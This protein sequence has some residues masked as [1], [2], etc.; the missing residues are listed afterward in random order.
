MQAK[1]HE[2]IKEH[3]GASEKVHALKKGS[4]K[5]VEA[6][7]QLSATQQQMDL[8]SFAYV[9]KLS[10]TNIDVALAMLDKFSLFFGEET[11]L[12]MS[13]NSSTAAIIPELTKQQAELKKQRQLCEQERAKELKK[14]ESINSEPSLKSGAAPALQIKQGLIFCRISGKYRQRW[15]SILNARLFV[16]KHWQASDAEKVFNL[17]LCNVKRVAADSSSHPF[18]FEIRSHMDDHMQFAATDELEMT[19]WINVIQNNIASQLTTLAPGASASD[20]SSANS[21][22]NATTSASDAYQL[23]SRVKGN[24]KCADCRAPGTLFYML[25]PFQFSFK[26][27]SKSL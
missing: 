4:P 27:P 18:V 13:V 21:G 1:V 7:L 10:Q 14:H 12:F 17:V 25:V 22:S 6:Q 5:L 3:E 15:C 23:I 20:A 26:R 11:V 2:A 19:Q 9:N 16:Y 8:L 24:E